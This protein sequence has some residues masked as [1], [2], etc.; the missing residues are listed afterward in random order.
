M[1]FSW[2]VSLLK[3]VVNQPPYK[4]AAMG[5]RAV[6]PTSEC[7]D[8]TC[9]A[10]ASNAYLSLQTVN[11]GQYG[12]LTFAFWFKAKSESGA[13]S[14]VLDFGRGAN[15]DNIVV[16]RKG[17]TDQMSFTVRVTSAG[18]AMTTSVSGVWQA[19]VWR[20]VVW[21]LA[22]TGTGTGATWRVYVDGVLG[23]VADGA[24]PVNADLTQNYIGKGSGA[25]D[26]AFVGYMD[27][28]VMFPDAMSEDYVQVV[29]QVGQ[30]LCVCVCVVARLALHQMPNVAP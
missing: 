11:F 21:T 9:V 7:K 1:Q 14:T 27:S 6:S 4:V 28:L 15:A 10:L 25:L 29:F 17:D 30:A 8:Q 16:A 5:I 26:A 18:V 20:H 24:Y 2:D 12:G 3:D 19:N 23:A 13:G 22:P